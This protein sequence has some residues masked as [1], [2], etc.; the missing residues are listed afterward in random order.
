M[1]QPHH[2]QGSIDQYLLDYIPVGLIEHP[3]NAFTFL[4]RFVAATKA[5]IWLS[6][7]LPMDGSAMTSSRQFIP[8]SNSITNNK[9]N[10]INNITN[11]TRIE[12]TELVDG[13]MIVEGAMLLSG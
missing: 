5:S 11:I 12:N 9:S 6:A 4:S 2:D 7:V 3:N 8:C 13:S 10:N 1:A